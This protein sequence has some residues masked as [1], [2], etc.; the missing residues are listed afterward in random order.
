MGWCD[1]DRSGSGWGEVEDSCESGND[2]SS[3]IN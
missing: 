2:P 3:S 1:L